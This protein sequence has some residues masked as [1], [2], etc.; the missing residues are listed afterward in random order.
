ML[1]SRLFY[2]GKKFL[3][4]SQNIA[5][6]LHFLFSCVLQKNDE[7]PQFIQN[8]VNSGINLVNG[9]N[10]G[11]IIVRDMPGSNSTTRSTLLFFLFC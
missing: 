5:S 7:K 4:L 1:N 2:A 9:S 8:V 6:L 11:T 3:I 10:S